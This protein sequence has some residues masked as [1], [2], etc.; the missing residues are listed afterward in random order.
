MMNVSVAMCTYN[1]GR[2]LAEQLRSI[3]EQTTPPYEIV[4][5]D[6][7]STDGT[8]EIV[9]RFAHGAPYPVRLFRNQVTLGSTKNFEKAISFCTGDVIALCDQDDVWQREKLERMTEA[10]T[11]DPGL[12]GVIADAWLIDENARRLPQSLWERRGF[13]SRM[14]TALSGKSGALL[15]LNKNVVTGATFIFRT[16]FVRLVTPIPGEWVHDAWIALLIATQARLWTL[17]E[18]LISYR[19]HQTQ[20]IGMTSPAWWHS[21]STATGNDKGHDVLVRRLDSLVSK[22]ED[23]PVDPRVKELAQQRLS[24]LQTRTALRQGG[25]VGRTLRATMTLPGYFRFSR[26]LFSY[27]RDLTRS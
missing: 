12:G 11:R 2:Y 16:H 25:F 3:G 4:I 23:L 6:D 19:L 7:G 14:Q 9:E 13:T 18:R 20:Q 27:G 17:P 24:F 21:L 22:F 5:C 1:G 8:C 26:G 10:F 15:L